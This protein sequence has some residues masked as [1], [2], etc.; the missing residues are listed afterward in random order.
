MAEFNPNKDEFNPNKWEFKRGY[1]YKEEEFK[2]KLIPWI[3]DT[4]IDQNIS[5]EI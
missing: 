3:N 5:V 2:P 1:D 4:Q